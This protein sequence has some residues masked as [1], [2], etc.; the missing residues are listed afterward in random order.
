MYQFQ[1]IQLKVEKNILNIGD[2]TNGYILNK[3][4]C[5]TGGNDP[6]FV[7]I[8]YELSL[9]ADVMWCAWSREI[10]K[11]EWCNN[12]VMYLSLINPL[13][14]YNS[15]IRSFGST[16]KVQPT[17]LRCITALKRWTD[18]CLVLDEEIPFCCQHSSEKSREMTFKVKYS[19]STYY[20]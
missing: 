2:N 10:L 4:A 6:Y 13:H 9:G 7:P 17:S 20:F 19:I 8:Q 12:W 1:Y 3:N 5:I 14:N 11:N 18:Y 16:N 15:T